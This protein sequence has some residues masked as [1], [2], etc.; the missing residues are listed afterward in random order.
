MTTNWFLNRGGSLS[1]MKTV[2]GKASSQIEPSRD[3]LVVNF[4]I[5]EPG[6]LA[7][8]VAPLPT[9]NATHIAILI[10]MINLPGQCSWSWNWLKW[11]WYVRPNISRTNSM[12]VVVAMKTVPRVIRP[13]PES[14]FLNGFPKVLIILWMFLRSTGC[15][16]R[17]LACILDRIPIRDW[18]PS[19][20]EDAA[21]ADWP[22]ED[23]AVVMVRSAMLMVV[24]PLAR[25]T[26]SNAI[27]C[28]LAPW[29]ISEMKSIGI[30]EYCQRRPL[31]SLL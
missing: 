6:T 24:H 13:T 17:N 4:C 19:S 26:S 11:S 25:N 23:G 30:K 3:I 18:S 7:A 31:P 12:N 22:T 20:T 27:M 14:F 5:A 9:M 28:S 8:Y 29:L 10:T 15:F 21:L 16:F 2:T 1:A